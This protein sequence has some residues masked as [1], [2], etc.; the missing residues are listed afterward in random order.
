MFHRP[1]ICI[2]DFEAV[3]MPHVADLYRCASWLVQDSWEAEDLVQEVY[4]EAWKSFHRFEPGTNCRAWLFKILFHRLHHLRRRL[5]R[6]SRLESLE[7]GGDLDSL[8]AEPPVP[9]EIRDDDILL[10]LAKLPLDFREVVVMADVQEFSYKE[11]AETLK[12]PLGT[13]MSR[14]SRGRKLLRQ[15]LAG[16]ARAYG[17]EPAEEHEGESA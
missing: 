14:L 17:V 15:E 7:S 5:W 11:I 16:V 2:D 9:Q 3:A 10:A 1:K 6:A 4:L 12:I 8:V 13:V